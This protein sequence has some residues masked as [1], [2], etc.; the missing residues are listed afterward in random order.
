MLTPSEIYLFL[1]K[2][3]ILMALNY[4]VHIYCTSTLVALSVNNLFKFLSVVRC[5]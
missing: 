3:L 2:V 1:C 4:D 5:I